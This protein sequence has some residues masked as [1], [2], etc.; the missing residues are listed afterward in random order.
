[1]EH[2]NTDAWE[3]DYVRTWVGNGVFILVWRAQP[4]RG[5]SREGLVTRTY[6]FGDP[7]M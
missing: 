6:Q 5:K 3:L 4:L 7:G 1:M 2:G